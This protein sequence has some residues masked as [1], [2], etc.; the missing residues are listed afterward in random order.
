MSF[1]RNQ[2]LILQLD[3]LPVAR[4]LHAYA[5]LQIALLPHVVPDALAQGT[6]IPMTVFLETNV[7]IVAKYYEKAE[8][9]SK[10]S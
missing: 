9:L 3:T 5:E 10:R 6:D 1:Y 2:Y 8:A 4:D 7:P